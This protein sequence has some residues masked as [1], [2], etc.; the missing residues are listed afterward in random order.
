MTDATAGRPPRRFG[1]A[2]PWFVAA[3]VLTTLG[4]PVVQ[5][6]SEIRVASAVGYATGAPT[7]ETIEVNLTDAPSYAPQYVSVPSNSTVDLHL[8]N[9][10]AYNHTFTLSNRSGVRLASNATPSEV[11]SFFRTNGARANLSLGPG[12]SGWANLSFNASSAYDSFEFASVVPYQFQAGMWGILNVTSTGPGL[13]V[14]ENTTDSPGFQPDVLSASPARYPAAVDVLVTNLG[15][16]GHTFTVVPQWNV[17]LTVG[18]YSSYFSTH[19][20]LVS[21]T[22]PS[23]AG[24]T[25]WANFTIPAPGVYMYLCLVPG[26]FAAGMM[27]DLYVGIP[28]PPAPASPSTAIVDTWILAGSAVLFGIGLVLAAVASYSGRFPKAPSSQGKGH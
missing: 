13:L 21:Q 16:L 23:G 18:N 4:L 8:R 19:P 6:L 9:L 20:P 2:A 15:S 14:Q 3:L 7:N 25:A 5:G 10:G 26:H 17:T 1:A 22:V 27:G 11:Y 28:V 24:M 12:A